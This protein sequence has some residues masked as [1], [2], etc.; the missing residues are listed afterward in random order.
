MY[1]KLICLLFLSAFF[2]S[3]TNDCYKKYGITEG[4]V[5]FLNVEL[6]N[7]SFCDLADRASKGDEDAIIKIINIKSFDGLCSEHG[8]VILYIIK[9][10]SEKRFLEI[11]IKNRDK[12]DIQRLKMLII[13]GCDYSTLN[14]VKNREVSSTFP[15]LSNYLW[16]NTVRHD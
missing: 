15:L 1:N 11:I 6:E 5:Y 4:G 12:I 13:V 16:P 10:C 8:V 3:C 14:K 2:A 7:D 9:S